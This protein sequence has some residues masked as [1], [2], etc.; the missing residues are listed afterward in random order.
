MAS[1]KIFEKTL[2]IFR[3]DFRLNDNTG[4]LK[5]LEDSE[6]VI[7]IFIYDDF[8]SKKFK[9]SNF[10]W[11]F[12]NESLL[13]L[14][15]QLKKQKSH[16]QVFKGVPKKILKKIIKNHKIDS[17]FL[18]TDFSAYSKSRD[19]E[20]N[21]ICKNSKI[22]F[23]SHLDFLLHNPIEIK[24]NMGKPYTVYSQFYK[25]AKQYPVRKTQKKLKGNFFQNKIDDSLI[26]SQSENSQIP[27]GRKYGLR[28][29][30]NLEFFKD[31][32]KTRNYPSISTT[33][34]SSHIKFGTVSVREIHDCIL[35]I[36]NSSHPLMGEIYWR[37][38]FNYILFHFP[39]ATKQS[40][41]EKYRNICWSKDKDKFHAWCNGKTGFPIVDAG[42]RELN[43]TGFMHNRLRM[44]TA[45]FLTKD[46]RIDWKLGERYFAKNLID[47][48]PAV[49]SGN[50]Q[51]AASTGCDAVP[52]FRIF[53]PWL[54]QEKFD[55]DCLYI[56]KWVPE[57]ELLKPEEIHNLWKRFPQNLNYPK[58]MVNHKLESQRT[59][60]FFKKFS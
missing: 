56:K 33:K 16:L 35:G 13:D 57:L 27:G 53:N 50:W 4:L 28:I 45:S 34:L 46:L 31:Y 10:R 6:V 12:L 3:R 1:K 49:N 11:S 23:S 60:E 54:Q 9:D 32:E 38:F 36:F 48:D 19:A 24:T 21:Q 15:D 59:K 20:I 5:A 47:Y 2:F 37:E 22:E 44:I 42:M 26:A 39:W 7:P 55:K 40:F 8:F 14:N 41:K 30:K 17:I 25:K 52:Y 29:L 51:W 43:Q 58:P 18:N